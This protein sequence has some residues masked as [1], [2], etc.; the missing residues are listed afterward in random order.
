MKRIFWILLVYAIIGCNGRR[1]VI[2]TGL[3]GTLLP[4]FSLLYIDSVTYINTSSFPVNKPVVLFYFS[5]HCPY[6]RAQTED[7]IDNMKSLSDITICMFSNFPLKN[8][9]DYY[10]HY[11]LAKYPNIIVGQDYKVYFSKHFNAIGVPYLAIYNREK[12][13]NS[14]LM[15]K[16]NISEIKEL[17][18]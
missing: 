3:E 13:L 4:S 18:E 16:V 9:K 10:K 14:V 11:D 8:I 15:G 12:K 6:C 7:F 2:K 5:P 17:A 1:T